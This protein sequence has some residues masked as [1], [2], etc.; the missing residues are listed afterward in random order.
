M[1]NRRVGIVDLDT[2]HPGNWVPIIRELGYE[3]AGVYDGGTVH[4]A[5]YAEQFARNHGIDRIFVS[6]EQMAGEV[7]IAIIHTVDW[8]LHV[9]RATPFIEAGV[10]VLIDKPFAGSVSDLRRLLAWQKEGSRIIGGSSLAVCAEVVDWHERRDHADGI[11]SVFGGCAVDEF[12]YGIHAYSMMLGILGPGIEKVRSLGT[13]VQHQVELVWHD[14]GRAIV[15]VGGTAGYLPFYATIVT[16]KKVE[17]LQVN[18]SGLYRSL[19]ERSLPYLAGESEPFLDLASLLE[20]EF[21]AIAAKVSQADGGR[22][23]SLKE[24]DEQN[25]DGLY[26]GRTFAEQYRK[27]AKGF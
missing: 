27:K 5:G 24:L 20:P 23:V 17:H 6:L 22:F 11:V 25:G 7:D 15:N 19:L 4:E 14:G 16:E 26:D 3:I 9:E 2:S 13:Q 1:G 10:S 21:A 12:N 18:N 8:G